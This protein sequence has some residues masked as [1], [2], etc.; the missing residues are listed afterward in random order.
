[1][2]RAILE[3]RKTQTRRVM[4]PQPHVNKDGG[5]GYPPTK[6]RRHYTN[7]DHMKKGLPLDYSPCGVP[8]GRLWVRETFLEGE[9][10]DTGERGLFYKADGLLPNDWP[11]EEYKWTPSIHM[12]RWASRIILEITNVRIEKVQ[13]ITEE[14]AKVEGSFLVRCS[15]PAMQKKPKTP[16]E[17]LFRQTGCHIHGIEFKAL[18]DSINAKRGYGWNE[19]PWVWV[20]E[21]KKVN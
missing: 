10:Y 4:K 6:K 21:F 16:I 14:D 11:L 9:N 3:G 12:P 20:I 1:M 2:V 7:I 18:W 15:C 19:N 17:A 5:I 8:G 13:E